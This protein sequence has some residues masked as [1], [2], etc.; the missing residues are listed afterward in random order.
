MIGGYLMDG[1]LA[2]QVNARIADGGSKQVHADH[3]G[4]GD[5][6]AHAGQVGVGFGAGMHKL[7][8]GNNGLLQGLHRL[9]AIALSNHPADGLHRHLSRHLTGAVTADAI[10]QHCQQRRGSMVI[11]QNE[12][13]DAIAIFVLPAPGARMAVRGNVEMGALD[14]DHAGSPATSIWG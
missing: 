14:R 9:A 6:G 4:A 10:C 3:P 8:G 13:R 2:H 7:A 5:R 12:R 11:L 1:V